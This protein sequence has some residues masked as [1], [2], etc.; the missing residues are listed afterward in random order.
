MAIP[1]YIL[2]RPVVYL[3]A[4]IAF[5]H[6]SKRRH[7]SRRPFTVIIASVFLIT[8][9][10]AVYEG[11]AARNV[12]GVIKL[13]GLHVP[14]PIAKALLENVGLFAIVASVLLL[15]RRRLETARREV[16][17]LA[18][19]AY[20][21]ADAIAS[22]DAGGAI[23]SWNLGAEMVFGQPAQVMQGQRISRL[24]AGDDWKKVSKGIGQCL[25]EGFL[26]GLSCRMFARGRREILVE[27][28]LSAM[29]DDEGKTSGVS[30]FM[31]DITEQ[32]EAQQ[33]LLHQARMEAVEAL[34]SGVV[35][36]F[37]N[38]LTVISGKARLGASAEDMDEAA[39]AFAAIESCAIR[40]KTVTANLI[41]CAG[42]Q[43]P[44]RAM[45]CIPD[46][47]DA[48]V[49][50]LRSEIAQCGVELTR[51]YQEVPETAF[52]P[53]QMS[54]VF[55]NL[56][57]NSLN[58]LRG[59]GGRIDLAV[60]SRHGFIETAVTDDGPSIPPERLE[61]T[62]EPFSLS[63]ESEHRVRTGS[64]AFFVCREIIKYHAGDISVDA[65]VDETTV[66]VYLP[67]RKTDRHPGS[68]G[69][70]A[71]LTRRRCTTAVVDSDA[72]IRDLLA[73][74]LQ[75]KGHRVS[76]FADAREAGAAGFPDGFDVGMVDVSLRT[77]DG[78]RYVETLK[79]SPGTLIFAVVGEVMPAGELD[80]ITDGLAGALH[81]PFGLEEINDLCNAFAP[82]GEPAGAG[83]RP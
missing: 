28:T 81:K 37:A 61:E 21:S 48:A 18:R 76:V 83:R 71:R 8:A 23:T 55:T 15:Q 34:S 65:G 63:G 12:D 51:N 59:R 20:S 32:E 41:A 44:Q 14:Y 56:L 46:T 53:E 67:V 33:E 38:L 6:I 69:G 64:L 77:A 13:A 82:E 57:V 11:A 60:S 45:G 16:R 50:A 31:R 2:V 62:F 17:Q 66:H 39:G 49:E 75:R 35:E 79:D 68:S 47:L 58:A 78:R 80:A 24:V 5:W 25:S 4:V 9:A 27:M 30:L 54:Q 26:R 42:R 1:F 19:I 40:A 73:Q 36:E 52:D 10:I 22:I 70:N 74:V 7:D 29:T 3:L 72:M 43:P